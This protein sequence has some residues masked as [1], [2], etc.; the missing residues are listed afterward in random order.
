MGLYPVEWR[1]HYGTEVSGLIDESE[2]SM[3][4]A[5]DL[6]R[7]AIHEHLK[8]GVQM[9]F[10]PAHSHP[11][12]FALVAAL[13]VAPT[14]IVVAVSLL[15]HELGITAIATATDPLIAWIGTVRFLDLFLVLAPLAA[16]MLA[17]LPLLDVRLDRD[18][19]APALA[20]RIR[21]VTANVVVC[22]VALVIGATLVWHVVVE[23]VLRTGA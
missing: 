22:A 9:R 18:D 8:G 17:A 3:A 6:A 20:V 10:D 11:G 7:A 14:L 5:M 2:S 21:A 15:G 4:D 19:G 23:S 16:F 12:T 13:L 1:S